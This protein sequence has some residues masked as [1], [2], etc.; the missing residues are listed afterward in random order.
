MRSIIV[1]IDYGTINIVMGSVGSI[2]SVVMDVELTV[3]D[4]NI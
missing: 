1:K 2:T 3:F 4:L